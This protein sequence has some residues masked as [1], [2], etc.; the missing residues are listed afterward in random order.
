MSGWESSY[1]VY[2]FGFCCV[3]PAKNTKAY[4][5]TFTNFSAQELLFNVQL[6]WTLLFRYTIVQML[7][8][9]K[10]LLILLFISLYI[11]LIKSDSKY[12]YNLLQ[13]IRN[14]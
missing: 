7:V 12:I 6:N 1:Y 11:K 9:S 8:V 14:I 3:Y 5:V 4:T 13:I 2:K 10:I